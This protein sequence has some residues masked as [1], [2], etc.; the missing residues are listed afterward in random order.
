M[1]TGH[2][3]KPDEIVFNAAI[4]AGD[5]EFKIIPKTFYLSFIRDAFRQLNLQSFFMEQ[6]KDYKFPE[7][8]TLSL[9]EDCFNVLNVYIFNGK[10]CNVENSRIVHWKRNYYTKGGQGYIA[11]DKGNNNR[12]TYYDGRDLSGNDK[13]LIRYT[14][15]ESLNSVLF[16]NIQMGNIMFSSS[17]RSAGAK[18]HIHYNGTGGNILDEPIIPIYFKDAIEDFVIEAALRLRVASEPSN[19]RLYFPLMQTYTNRLD[20]NGM[21]GSWHEAVQASKK[22]N[23]SQRQDLALYLG[24]GPWLRGF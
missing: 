24:R 10:D 11:N 1:N 13:S 5:R 19:A 12:D 22:L 21:N 14:G 8:L 17:C 9:P 4:F 6:R 7:N 2:Y 3:I 20:K 15:G 16:Y 18:V 23:T